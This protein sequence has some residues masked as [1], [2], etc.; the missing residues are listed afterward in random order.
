[1]NILFWDL[2]NSVITSIN[3]CRLSDSI[4]CL[5]PENRSQS[6]VGILGTGSSEKGFLGMSEGDDAPF[7]SSLQDSLC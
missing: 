2:M 5:P 3:K 4:V 1:V 7:K 6:K